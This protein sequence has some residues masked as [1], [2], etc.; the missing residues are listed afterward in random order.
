M[1]DE[2][3]IK[4]APLSESGVVI[5]GGTSGVGLA[6]AH[7][8]VAAGV[9][10]LV[11]LGRN[12]DRGR[13]ARDAVLASCPEAQVEFISADANDPVQAIQAIERA[14]SLIG[15]LDVL[16]NSTTATYVPTLLHELAVEDI[17]GILTGQA[18]AP[19]HMTRAVLSVMR[20]QRGGAIINIASDA[21]KVATPGETILGSA[22]AAI[23]MFSRT[24][25]IEGKRD[26]I[27][28]NAI[29]PSLIMGTPTGERSL[30]GGFSAKL[31]TKALQQAHLGATVPDDLAGLIVFL[32]SPAAARLTG[33]AISVNGG[34]SAA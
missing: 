16:V 8:F 33:Q 3:N 23:V 5:T 11:L 12:E 24:V 29:T 15:S 30:E 27:R 2:R 9:R 34:I 18:L 10:R 22:M 26:G 21:A 14:H 28:V 1:A 7:Q 20:E 31:F 32:A 6:S 4:V 19:M 17:A 13:E 25:A